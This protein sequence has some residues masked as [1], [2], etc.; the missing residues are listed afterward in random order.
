MT[1]LA[2]ASAFPVRTDITDRAEPTAV[3][4][5]DEVILPARAEELQIR[6]IRIPA[7]QQAPAARRQQ[8][9]AR[10]VRRVHRQQTAAERVHRLRMPH[11]T[12]ASNTAGCQDKI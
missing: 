8:R 7:E 3:R 10:Q 11:N 12:K 9:R 2:R 4:P 6:M 1:Q 5:L